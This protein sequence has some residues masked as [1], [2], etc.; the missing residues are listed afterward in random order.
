M[1]PCWGPQLGLAAGKTP[2]ME[3]AQLG[4]E[5]CPALALVLPA[6]PLPE[7]LARVAFPEIPSLEGSGIFLRLSDSHFKAFA[8]LSEGATVAQGMPGH[9]DI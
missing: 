7:V 6:L 2:A 8:P 5:P 1:W 4:A 9:G 3:T